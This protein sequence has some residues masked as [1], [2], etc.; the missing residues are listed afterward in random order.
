MIRHDHP[1]PTCGVK[2]IVKYLIHD[3]LSV[4][5][6]LTILTSEVFFSTTA[7]ISLS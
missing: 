4:R 6:V 1:F 2:L 3:S 5:K 7:T